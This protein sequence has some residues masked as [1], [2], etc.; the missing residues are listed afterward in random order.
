MAV[1]AAGDD[2]SPDELLLSANEVEDENEYVDSDDS[3]AELLTPPEEE[4]E[5]LEDCANEEDRGRCT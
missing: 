1:V 5:E 2:A 3:I 4:I